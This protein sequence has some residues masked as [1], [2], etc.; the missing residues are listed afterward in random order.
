M[1]PE[2]IFALVGVFA[3][4]AIGVSI[5]TDTHSVGSVSATNGSVPVSA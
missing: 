1:T 4:V 2:L 3:A 5:I